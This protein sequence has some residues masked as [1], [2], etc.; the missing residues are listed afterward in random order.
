MNNED[1]ISSAKIME[2]ITN[3][4]PG[5][6]G[7]VKENSISNVWKKVVSNIGKK[8]VEFDEITIGEK[9]AANTHVV[10]F[11]DGVLLVEANHS[12]WIQY[13]RMYQKFILQGLKW[14]IPDLKITN[15]AY[16]VTGNAVNL[17]ESYEYQLD[18]SQKEMEQR[19]ERQERE[20]AEKFGEKEEKKSSSGQLPPE[21]I[22]KLQS[23]KQ[24]MLTNSKN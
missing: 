12:G 23:I 19:V 2:Q 22:E 3:F 24:S 10:D 7:S 21:L 11:K 1:M 17:S 15:L 5:L 16:R 4:I 13:L 14:N 6:S 8:N 18:K 20:L 9:I